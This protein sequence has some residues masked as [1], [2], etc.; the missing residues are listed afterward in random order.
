[1]TDPIAPVVAE[2]KSIWAKLATP[3]AW[4][5]GK[6]AAHPTIAGWLVIVLALLAIR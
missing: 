1:M 5:T 3:W 2:T 4:Y 6:I